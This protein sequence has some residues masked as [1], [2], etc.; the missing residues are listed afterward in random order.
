MTSQARRTTLF[1]L[2]ILYGFGFIDRVVIALVAQ[3]IKVELGISDF[4]IGLLGGSA[5]AIVNTLAAFPL[6]QLAERCRRSFVVAGSLAVGS[7]FTALCGL[8]ASFWHLLVLRMGM[9]IGSSGTEAPA[10]S[11]VSDMYGPSRR[12]SALALFMLGVPFASILG[13]YLGGYM[14]EQHGWRATFLTFGISGLAVALISMYLMH[15]PAR[16]QHDPQA[17][18]G[19]LPAIARHL[20]SHAHFRHLVIGTS[21]GSLATFGV[22]TFLPAFL[23]RN[24]G[25]G[26]SDAALL[27]GLIVGIASAVGTLM[28][29]FGSEWL[30]RRDARWLIGAPAAGLLVGAPLLMLGVT[31][32]NLALAVTLIFFASCFFYT[33]MG[34]AIAVT[35]RLL[36]SRS[37]AVGSAVFLLFMH[38]VGQGFGPPVIGLVSDQIAAR[39]SGDPELAAQCAQATSEVAISACDSASAIG[40]R[41]AIV[42]FALLYLWTAAHLIRATRAAGMHHEPRVR[43]SDAP[44]VQS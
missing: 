40:I 13:S 30:A 38:L 11:M 42:A 1:L 15:E 33:W 3:D 31:R 44:P 20:W 25:L 2:T 43:P 5:F 27:F 17:T 28:G 21:I 35:H 18:A 26:T 36:G 12:A 39:A 23:T 7:A 24:Y 16:D 19:S 8:A 29:G 37:R 41:Y 34:P 9:A 6:A 4:Q 32:S 14:G 10:H 22:N